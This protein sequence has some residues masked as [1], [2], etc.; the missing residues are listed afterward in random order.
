MLGFFQRTEVIVILMCLTL[1]VLG[2][3]FMGLVDRKASPGDYLWLKNVN[4]VWCVFIGPITFICGL[5]ALVERLNR[6]T[7]N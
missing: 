2:L 1:G 7:R 3:Y 4:I 5:Y 6:L